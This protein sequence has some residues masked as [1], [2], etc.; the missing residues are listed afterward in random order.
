MRGTQT[1]SDDTVNLESGDF[2]NLL[3]LMVDIIV[4]CFAIAPVVYIIAAITL[5]R[6]R[7]AKGVNFFSLLMLA[8]AIYSFGYFLEV[9]AVNAEFAFF[10]RNFEYLAASFIPALFL[11]FIV[12]NT[13]LFSPTKRLTASLCVLSAVIWLLYVTNP[14]LG[15]FYKSIEFELGRYGGMMLTQKSTGFYLLILYYILVIAAAG[16]LLIK[17]EKSAKA[18]HVKKSFRFMFFTFQIPWLTVIF[19]V[20]GFDKHVDPVPFTLMIVGALL[21]YNELHNDMFERQTNRWI[22]NYSAVREPGLL[23]DTNGVVIRQ[24]IAAV[25]LASDLGKNPEE[26][27]SAI[28]QAQK[29]RMPVMFT[30]RDESKWFDVKKSVFNTKSTLVSYLLTDVTREKNISVVAE[31]FFNAIGDYVFAVSSSDEILF[32]NNEFKAGLGYDDKAIRQMKISDIFPN[33][34]R[35]ETKRAFEQALSKDGNTLHLPLQKSDGT[36]VSVE[37]RIWPG[38]WN[39]EPVL[40]GMSKDITMFEESEAKFK[41]SFYKNPAIMA[42]TDTDFGEFL[43]VND[44]FLKKLGYTKQEIIG[45][46][47]IDSNI[48]VDKNQP[49]AI[50]ER[51]QTHDE[52]TDVEIDI[53]A[54]NGD[55]FIGLFSAS[56][57]KTGN[58]SRLLTVMVDITENRKRANLLSILTAITQDFLV[59]RDYM[60]PVSRAF[61]VFGKALDVNR[62]FLIRCELVDEKIIKSI[63]PAAEWCSDGETPISDNPGFK[64]I[65]QNAINDYLCPVYNGQPYISNVSSM[66]TGPIKEF[67]TMLG[68]KTVLSIPV[69]ENESLWGAICLH[70][71]RNERIWTELEKNTVKVFADSLAMA[72]QKSKSMDKV[73]FLSFRDQLTGLY[74]RRFYKLEVLRLDDEQYF[75]L[76]MIMADVNGLKLVNDAFGHHA[77]DLILQ[78]FADILTKQCRQQ[79][80]VAR[81]GGDEFIVLLPNTDA[82]QTEAVIER[83]NTALEKKSGDDLVLSASIGFAVK[84]NIAEDMNDIFKQAEDMMYRNK[85]SESSSIRS[86]T[87]D[88]ILH[89]LFEKNNREMQHS[90]RVGDLCESIARA[91]KFSKANI[92]QMGIAG[93]MH[94]IGKIGISEETL[95]KPENLNTVEM[96]E[97]RRHSE[98]GYRILD[99]VSEFSQIAD[100]VL[101]HHER[102]DGKGYPKG[103]SGKEIS[104]QAKIIAIADAYDAMTSGRTYRERLSCAD[105][106]AEI[107]KG[108]GT[109]FDVRIAKVF[110]EKVLGKEW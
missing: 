52:L 104:Q 22:N 74:N 99:S 8:N 45:K 21:A 95:N 46:T 90:Q 31:L 76:A 13:K 110:V 34:F 73:E 12:Q 87:I 65:P 84:T 24:N 67:Y 78:R 57:I 55:I 50:K 39:G 72:I 2:L 10:V 98:I 81:I 107:K 47:V 42:I 108:S 41:K 63:S 26:I 1:S 70:E 53:H 71:C 20:L 11:L 82:T 4:S 27:L 64:T 68:I 94:D 79:D 43:D 33:D 106:A 35:Q 86:K 36:T 14:R 44:T 51:L 37:T 102:P 103:L 91:M 58:S 59:S 40:F 75:P 48:F 92:S 54:K 6:Q 80:T 85:L 77:G 19:V 62:V 89:S 105:A 29:N 18:I 97:I 25:K 96:A 56:L 60:L 17:A 83:I 3:D 109:Q 100:Y 28:D 93:M 88:L 38:D 30:V 61:T 23:F 9:N 15:I 66:P 49:L 101:E 32:A 7:P 16:L 5:W 69:F